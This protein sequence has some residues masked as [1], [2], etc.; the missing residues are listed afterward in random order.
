MS[1]V[2]TSYQKIRDYDFKPLM[3]PTGLVGVGSIAKADNG[4]IV[5]AGSKY[6]GSILGGIINHSLQCCIAVSTDNGVS[7]SI[8]QTISDASYETWAYGM[9][10]KNGVLFLS[11][12]KEYYTSNSTYQAQIWK[13]T[14]NG[15]TW[16]LVFSTSTYAIQMSN[17]FSGNTVAVALYKAVYPADY[18]TAD[19]DYG[20]LD[21]VNNTLSVSGRL[22]SHGDEGVGSFPSEIFSYQRPKDNA[23]IAAVRWG[24]YPSIPY[25]KFKISYDLGA[26]W[27][28][29]GMTW[30]GFAGM[31]SV[32][33]TLDGR[34]FA[35]G[36]YKPDL[37]TAITAVKEFDPDTVIVKSTW[38]PWGDNSV[39][40]NWVGNGQITCDSDGNLLLAEG[41]GSLHFAF[42]TSPLQDKSSKGEIGGF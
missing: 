1:K 14:D 6:T 26:T 32:T 15:L 40:T 39:G 34:F 25:L 20:W 18:L 3:E 16:N 36:Y 27:A 29:F 42:C 4:N 13:S 31:A 30:A 12:M 37:A 11:V 10:N 33:K 38:Y 28:D 35:C 5:V 7:F 19:V 24:E 21:L 9:I 23:I 17:I 2:F 41:N 22:A 8:V